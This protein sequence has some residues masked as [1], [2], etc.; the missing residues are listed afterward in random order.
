MNK[1]Q[2]IT[3]SRDDVGCSFSAY[4]RVDIEYDETTK[5]INTNFYVLESELM[6]KVA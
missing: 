6:V 2:Y 1:T 3:M 5:D 4:I